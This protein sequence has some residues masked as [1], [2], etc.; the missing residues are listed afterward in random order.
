MEKLKTHRALIRKSRQRK[1]LRVAA[2][3]GYTNAG[4]STFLRTLTGSDIVVADKLF[5]TLDP[6]TRSVM[7]PDSQQ[8]LFTDTVGFLLDLP[9]SLIHAFHPTLEE[10]HEAD[11]VLVIL[12]VSH[13]HYEMQYDVVQKTLKEIDASEKK[14]VLALNKV[15]ACSDEARERAMA[16]FPDGIPISAVTGQGLDVLLRTLCNRMQD[17]EH[18][19][20]VTS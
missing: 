13:A 7:M 4:K 14:Q 18:K 16:V 5:A 19:N 3:V 17:D 12:D 20:S 8:M 10:I 15:D 1:D 9:H 2:I 6:V 11:I